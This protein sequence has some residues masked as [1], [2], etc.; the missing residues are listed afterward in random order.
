[1]RTMWNVIRYAMMW[2]IVLA[3]PAQG[4]AAVAMTLCRPGDSIM[5]SAQVPMEYCH[6]GRDHGSDADASNSSSLATEA[7]PGAEASALSGTNQIDQLAQHDSSACTPWC[8][9]AGLPP[10][11]VTFDPPKAL[12]F[13]YAAPAAMNA[14][15][16]RG[17]L[18]RPPRTLLA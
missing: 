14:S 2:L 15:F 18:D 3:V 10:V 17:G 12:A 7:I 1:M 8:M 16:F 4:F 6:F 5:T 9:S 11:L 13:I